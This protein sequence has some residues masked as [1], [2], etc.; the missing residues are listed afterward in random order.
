MGPT[1][2]WPCGDT[3][4]PGLAPAHGI[5]DLPAQTKIRSQRAPFLVSLPLD[6][7]PHNPAPCAEWIDDKIEFVP[8][9]VATWSKI[10]NWFSCLFS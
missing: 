4:S 9:A 10:R 1:D 8:I 3:Q 5:Q 2:A 7:T 6:R